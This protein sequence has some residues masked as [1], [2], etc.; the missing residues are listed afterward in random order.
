MEILKFLLELWEVV[1]YL[2]GL[3]KRYL[4]VIDDSTLDQKLISVHIDR[5]GYKYDIAS[6]AEEGIGLLRAKR[7]RM[8]YVDM[9]L[10]QMDGAQFVE[11]VREVGCKTPIVLVLGLPGDVSRLGAGR[12]WM[13]IFKPVTAEAI[14]DS[15]WKIKA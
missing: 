8:A 10:P 4:L 9:R 13:V 5:A 11:V 6:N 7:Y 3:K 1:A 14:E 12:L 2:L 15:L